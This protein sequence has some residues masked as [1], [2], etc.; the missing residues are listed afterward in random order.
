MRTKIDREKN[1]VAQFERFEIEMSGNA[2]LDCSHSGDCAADVEA[3]A[4]DIKRDLKRCS[5]ERLAKELK[6]YGA[7]DGEELKDDTANWQRIVWIAAG[8]ICDGEG[9]EI[10]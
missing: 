5:P 10:K 1:Y 3:H 9:E 2:A 6:E 4:P 8:N 7:W